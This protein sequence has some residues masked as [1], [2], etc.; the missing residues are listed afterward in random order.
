MPMILVALIG[1]FYVIKIYKECKPERLAGMMNRRGP[2]ARLILEPHLDEAA[3]RAEELRGQCES[4][5]MGTAI[6]SAALAIEAKMLA[7]GFHSATLSDG[8]F[9]DAFWEYGDTVS[10]AEIAAMQ[11]EV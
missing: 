5:P 1:I 3:E 2:I 4:L 8:N 11:A 6:Y 7:K 10:A 9:R